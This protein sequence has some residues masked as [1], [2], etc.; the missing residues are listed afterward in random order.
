MFE[1]KT[2]YLI[3]GNIKNILFIENPENEDGFGYCI[4]KVIVNGESIFNG[5]DCNKIELD[6]KA[7]NFKA[8]E[9]IYIILHHEKGC[10]PKI[11]NLIK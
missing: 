7:F 5:T 3:N 11:L 1:T 2:T 9:S 4:T 6:L 8:G 10:E